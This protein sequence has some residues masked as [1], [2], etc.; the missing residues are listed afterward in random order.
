MSSFGWCIYETGT[1]CF[2]LNSTG[3]TT[4]PE[5]NCECFIFLPVAHL[6]NET[7]QHSTGSIDVFSRK[8][9][10][11]KN[12]GINLWNGRVGIPIQTSLN[13]LVTTDQWELKQQIQF[14]TINH[15]IFIIGYMITNTR[16]FTFSTL[17]CNFYNAVV[18]EFPANSNILSV[19][20]VYLRT[21]LIAER[22]M[23]TRIYGRW[24]IIVSQR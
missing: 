1:L 5:L 17:V 3:Q 14:W 23:A 8:C 9:D 18:H 20:S 10:V 21:P 12:I 4:K 24:K 7:F 16:A 2:D 19:V 22:Y 13:T 15:T 11:S 6:P